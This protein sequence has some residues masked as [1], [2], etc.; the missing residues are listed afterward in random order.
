[1][2]I[3]GTLRMSATEKMVKAEQK[4]VILGKSLKLL[5]EESVPRKTRGTSSELLHDLLQIPKGKGIAVTKAEF[6]ITPNA[7]RVRINRL[8]RKGQLPKSYQIMG[9]TVDGK[10]V[11]YVMHSAEIED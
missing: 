5:S 1:M 4:I 11:L 3:G 2:D 8:M 6:G 10:K 9:R 7:M